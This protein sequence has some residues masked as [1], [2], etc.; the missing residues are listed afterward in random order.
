MTG[1]TAL[2]N[3]LQTGDL[4]SFFWTIIPAIILFIAMIGTIMVI[5]SIFF[6]TIKRTNKK[7]K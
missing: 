6:P 2:Y 3:L 1:H 4:L 7:K 5:R